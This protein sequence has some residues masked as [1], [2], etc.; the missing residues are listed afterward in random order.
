MP[1]TT[2]KLYIGNLPDHCKEDTIRDLFNPYGEVSDLAV[3]KNF[4]F[5]HFKDEGEAKNAVRDL[6]GAKLLGKEIN[7]EISKSKGEKERSGGKRMNSRMNGQRRDPPR[8]SGNINHGRDLQQ[9][10]LNLTGGILGQGPSIDSRAPPV[11]GNFGILSAVNTLAAVAEKQKQIAQKG[12][13]TQRN[14]D[15]LPAR[16]SER[17]SD[18]PRRDQTQ[19][20]RDTSDA[21]AVSN[22]NGY[23]I[24]ERYYVDPSHA[25]LK[26]LPLP[27]LPRAKGSHV[28]YPEKSS[29]STDNFASRDASRSDLY[30]SRDL[31]T[32][33]T[34]SPLTSRREFDSERWNPINY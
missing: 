3:I 21:K 28:G 1:A 17:D 13:E 32:Y 27:E 8:D 20:T 6:N 33:R 25:L 34:R 9:N 11:L 10:L 29:V 18:I 4:A 5:V 7:V 31:D 24:Y 15:P 12:L 16:Q 30:S 22:N 19:T 23:V 26:G 14:M 2:T